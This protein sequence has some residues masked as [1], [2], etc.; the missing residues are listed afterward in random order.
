[1]A[2][3]IDAQQVIVAMQA[4]I[5][6]QALEIAK[7]QVIINARNQTIQA[8]QAVIGEYEARYLAE[9]TTGTEG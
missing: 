4:Q 6:A 5:G 2:E 1:M 8:Q 3:Q 9:G 7:A